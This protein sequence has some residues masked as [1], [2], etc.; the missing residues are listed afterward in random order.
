MSNGEKTE[1]VSYQ[2]FYD[3]FVNSQGKRLGKMENAEDMFHLIAKHAPEKNRDRADMQKTYEK[4]HIKDG[5]L[6]PKAVVEEG[7]EPPACNWFKGT[8]EDGKEQNMIE[9]EKFG[10]QVKFRIYTNYKE[11]TD[12]KDKEKKIIKANKSPWQTVGYPFFY[13]LLQRYQS[14]P[15]KNP[16]A[17]D[18]K[19]ETPDRDEKM[20][21]GFFGHIFKNW[22]SISSLMKGIEMS[23]KGIKEKL[24]NETELH[25]AEFARTLGKIIPMESLRDDLDARAVSAQHKTIDKVKDELRQGASGD[26]RRQKIRKILLNKNSTRNEIYAAMLVQL[27]TAG[28]LYTA[29][30]LQELNGTHIWTKRLGFSMTEYNEMVA[31]VLEEPADQKGNKPFITE[32]Y[33][34]W[35]LLKKF[36]TEKKENR[37]RVLAGF[38]PK[39][40]KAWKE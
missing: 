40:Y 21:G 12:P 15:V 38:H 13:T 30:N 28:A 32:E 19:I 37:G 36:D 34:I 14:I 20:T 39:M 22:K 35:R 5:K 26:K 23:W 31:K 25:A 33:I 27:E 6:V 18:E 29:S 7:K 8:N 2:E 1:K 11:E 17:P 16:V 24:G 3:V 9:V 10:D 4:F